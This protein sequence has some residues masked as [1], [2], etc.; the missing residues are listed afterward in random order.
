MKSLFSKQFL[1]SQCELLL[2]HKERLTN[3]LAFMREEMKIPPEEIMESGDLANSH[4]GQSISMELQ[5]KDM[6]L[7]REIDEALMRIEEGT[8]GLCQETGE[9][10]AKERLER[11]PWARL[12]LE[13]AEE[14][15]EEAKLIAFPKAA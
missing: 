3:N 4:V 14:L 6:Q 2:G 13:A 10:I 5:E 11:L 9:A 12:S 7:M 15:E 1:D 8:Y